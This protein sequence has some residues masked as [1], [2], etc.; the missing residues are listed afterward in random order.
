MKTTSHQTIKSIIAGVCLI[1]FIGSLHAWEPNVKDLDAAL[2]TGEFAPYNTN[3]RDWLVKKAPADP[4]KI[5]HPTLTALLQNATVAPVLAQYQFINKVGVG[6]L[7]AFAKADPANKEFLSWVMKNRN[8]MELLLEGA[9]PVRIAARDDNSWSISTNTLETWKK[10]RIADPDS[11]DGIYLHLAMATALRPP[12]TGSPGSGQQKTPSDPVVR[13]KYF[14]TAHA[15]KELFPSF[16]KLTV[17]DY[18]FVVNSGASEADLTWGREMVNTWNPTFKIN[19]KV[20]DTTSCVWRRNSPVSHID[21]KTVLDGGGKCGPRSS[22]SVFICQ[23]WGIPA[24][25]V[26]QPAH[27]CVAY[28]A[29]DG[30]WQVAYGR[31]WNASKLEGMSGEEFVQGTEARLLTNAFSQVEHMRW[32]STVM[33]SKEHSAAVLAVAKSITD[34]LAVTKRDLEASEKV[35]EMDAD[36]GAVVSTK[37]AAAKPPVVAE[38]PYKPVPGVIHVDGASFFETGGITVWGGEPRVSVLDSTTG[39]K[40]LLFPQ[41]MASCWVGYKINVP[42]TGIYEMTAKVATINSGQAFSVRSFGA[43][44]KAVSATATNVYNNQVKDLGPQMAIDNNPSTRWACSLGVDDVILALDLGKPTK[45][46]TVMIDERAYGK[47]SKFVLE[48]QDGT[49]WKNLI[50]GT[51][52]G[53]DYAQ[54]FPPV[55]A[56]HVRLHTLDNSGNTGGPTIW[57]FSVGSVRDGQVWMALPWTAGLWQTTPPSDIRLVKGE[58]TIWINAPYQRGVAMKHFDLKAKGK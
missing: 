15:N 27:A 45:I 6:Q 47:I 35:A 52:I 24:I 22:W 18:Q 30:H 7:S 42:E 43:M 48:Y 49:Q 56:Q 55:T 28:K 33:P 57:E 38:P 10:I 13:Y 25:G 9:T 29:N 44:A 2:N 39:G 1:P 4:A 58:Q 41:G 11:K 17:W 34:A 31:G 50:T 8:V 53:S 51:T 36:S 37:G 54:D 5:T 40:Q 46:S 19:E 32:L 20:V 16:D 26:G 3:L 21:Y 23:A 14:K 12:G